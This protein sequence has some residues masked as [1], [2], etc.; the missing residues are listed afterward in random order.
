V[1]HIVE[2]HDGAIEVTSEL[3]QGSTFEVRLPTPPGT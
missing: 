2:N 3:G 1:R